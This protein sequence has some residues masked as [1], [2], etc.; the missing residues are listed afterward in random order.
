MELDFEYLQKLKNDPRLQDI[1]YGKC[2]ND[3]YYFLTNWAKTLD[4]HDHSIKTFPKKLYIKTLIDIWLKNKLL[5]VPKSR[6]M[7]VSWLFVGLYLWDVQFH[8]NSLVFFQSKKADD[9]DDLVKRAK[10][11]WDNEPN[12][13][14]RHYDNLRGFQELKCNPQHMGQ[15]VYCR[16]SFPDINSEIRGVPEGGDIVRMHTLSGLLSDEMAFQP[17][18][19]SSY[20]AVK[21]SLSAGGRYTCVSTAEDLSFFDDLVYDRLEM[22]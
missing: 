8:K 13:L 3:P 6:Q 21:P 5:L 17:E 15:Q 12:F 18:A 16:L 10:F 11:I 20:I 9:A 19:K 4:V 2:A 7:M 1:E 14:K 22:I